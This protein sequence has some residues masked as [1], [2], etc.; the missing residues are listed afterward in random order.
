MNK[1]H[2]IKV[3]HG[4]TEWKKYIHEF[5]EDISKTL[6]NK[7]ITFWVN[8]KG[9]EVFY[10]HTSEESNYRAFESQFY[11]YFKNFLTQSKN[12]IHELL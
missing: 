11:S 12:E 3:Y 10:S 4:Y 5:F 1:T 8:F 6:E 9:G 2:L 7:K